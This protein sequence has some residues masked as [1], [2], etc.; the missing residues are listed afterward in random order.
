MIRQFSRVCESISIRNYVSLT[1]LPTKSAPA[2]YS[3]YSD[4]WKKIEKEVTWYC[5]R[6]TNLNVRRATWP[7]M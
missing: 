7:T 5:M 1:C 2:S 4:G 3:V 6:G